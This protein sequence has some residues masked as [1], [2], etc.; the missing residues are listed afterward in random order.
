MPGLTAPATETPTNASAPVQRLLERPQPR[1]AREAL[2]VLVEIG[3]AQMH[4][5][6]AV[7]ERQV[8][9]AHAEREEQSAQ[10]IAA[11]PAPEKTTLTSPIRFA[12]DFQGV[13]ERRA[14]DDRRAVL[15]VVEDR[16]RHRLAQLL[17]DVKALGAP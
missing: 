13:Q 3:P 11:A 8:L 14:G 12:G 10:A 4:D 15:V 2:L 1:F 7:A 6:L 17:F 16:D 5:A 9:R